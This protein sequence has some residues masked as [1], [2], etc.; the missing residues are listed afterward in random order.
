MSEDGLERRR[1]F[2]SLGEDFIEFIR[3]ARSTQERGTRE[4]PR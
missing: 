4:T 1:V 3:N 2:S